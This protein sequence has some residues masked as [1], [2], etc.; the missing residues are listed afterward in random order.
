MTGADL[1]GKEWERRSAIILVGGQARRVG[2][3]EKY[4][5]QFEGRTFIERLISTLEGVVGEILLVARDPGQCSRFSQFTTVRCTCDQTPGLG[6]VG[7]LKSGI[8]EIKGDFVFVTAC[9][10]PC[11]REEVVNFLF[12]RLGEHDALVPAWDEEKYEPLHAVYRTAAL[13]EVLE[14]GGAN[15]PRQV[16]RK[17]HTAFIPV[18]DL[19]FF[20]PD[21]KGFTNINHPGD[22]HTLTASKKP[23]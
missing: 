8:R 11:I 9:D 13:K 15:S 2:G 10:M 20:D 5:F 23:E 17:L 22:L 3:Q 12:E 4:F 21:L 18:D 14:G 1:A 16:I 6:P 7:G 19:R